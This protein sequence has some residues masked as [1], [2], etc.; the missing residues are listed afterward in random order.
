MM[1]LKHLTILAVLISL[2]GQLSVRAENPQHVRRL[3]E[4]KE[5]RGCNLGNVNLR[6]ADL[7][8]VDLRDA[9]LAGAN[10]E[11]ADLSGAKLVGADMSDTNLISAKLV[12]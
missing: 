9:Y 10:L 3:L 1:R 12:G 4:T 7:R 6:G 8:D 2:T 5:C 11:Q